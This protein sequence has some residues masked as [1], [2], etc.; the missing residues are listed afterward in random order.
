M[1]FSRIIKF[2]LF[3]MVICVVDF[4]FVYKVRKM[5]DIINSISGFFWGYILVYF[6]IVVGLFFIF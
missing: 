4:L 1:F 6:L 2:F 5:I 3:V